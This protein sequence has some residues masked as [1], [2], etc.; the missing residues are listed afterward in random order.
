MNKQMFLN[1]NNGLVGQSKA[2]WAMVQFFVMWGCLVHCRMLGISSRCPPSVTNALQWHSEMPPQ[3]LFDLHSDLPPPQHS[4]LPLQP[5]HTVLV[6]SGS[7]QPWFWL[8]F[9]QIF[10]LSCLALVLFCDYF[11]CWRVNTWSLTCQKNTPPLR[12]FQALFSEF[13]QY[14]LDVFFFLCV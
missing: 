1:L 4:C 8:S 10:F 5:P 14:F 13:F 11:Q 3:T 9:S 12:Y 2:V 7:S 6:R